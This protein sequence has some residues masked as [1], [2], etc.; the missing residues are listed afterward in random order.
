MSSFQMKFECNNAAFDDE[1]TFNLMEVQNI[2]GTVKYKLEGG[3]TDGV[4]KDTNGNTVGEWCLDV[5][6]PNLPQERGDQ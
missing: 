5:D 1:G 4:I 6:T 3:Y 2:L